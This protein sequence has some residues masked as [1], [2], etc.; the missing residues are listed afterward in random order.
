MALQL[1]AAAGDPKELW[2]VPRAQHVD[3]ARV[4]AEDYRTRVTEFFK[5]TLLQ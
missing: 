5:R 2:I 3:Y 1:Y 4:A